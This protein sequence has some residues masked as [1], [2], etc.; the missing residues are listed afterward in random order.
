MN[1]GILIPMKQFDDYTI[2]ERIQMMRT[3]IKKYLSLISS[4]RLMEVL[5]SIQ[6]AGPLTD[7]EI[8]E[9]RNKMETAKVEPDHGNIT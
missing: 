7:E 5:W 6:K 3:D 1:Y 8:T 4:D 2:E 9:L